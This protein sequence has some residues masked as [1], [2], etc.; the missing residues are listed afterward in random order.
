MRPFFLFLLLS[1]P[2]C[3]FLYMPGGEVVPPFPEE[4]F[5]IQAGISTGGGDVGGGVSLSDR[6]SITGR[7]TG[8]QKKDDR[9][10]FLKGV[11]SFFFIKPENDSNSFFAFSTL[12]G[13]AGGIHTTSRLITS[14]GM[15]STEIETTARGNLYSSGIGVGGGFLFPYGKIGTF[16]KGEEVFFQPSLP[17]GNLVPGKVYGIPVVSLIPYLEIH[18]NAPLYLYLQGGVVLPIPY[19]NRTPPILPLPYLIAFGI[20]FKKPP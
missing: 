6:L 15:K 5:K 2:S 1:F 3:I 9:R 13:G 16:L 8:N 18:P 17:L 19:G 11:G 4:S 7:F 20:G 10:F 12:E 14:F